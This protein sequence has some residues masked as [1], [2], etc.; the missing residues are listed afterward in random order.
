MHFTRHSNLVPSIIK[1][2]KLLN[3]KGVFIVMGGRGLINHA[4][5]SLPSCVDAFKSHTERTANGN[6]I[7]WC[8]S[9]SFGGDCPAWIYQ[10]TSPFGRCKSKHDIIQGQ[11]PMLCPSISTMTLILELNKFLFCIITTLG[12]T[13]TVLSNGKCVCWRERT[14]FMEIWPCINIRLELT[15]I[16]LQSLAKKALSPVEEAEHEAWQA[17]HLN[18]PDCKVELKVA[19]WGTT[20]TEV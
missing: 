8:T 1:F 19:S 6:S 9:S 14:P 10:S 11:I 7:A 4:G 13:V 15:W 16:G 17:T 18:D 20:C 5:R 12:A 2:C 3:V